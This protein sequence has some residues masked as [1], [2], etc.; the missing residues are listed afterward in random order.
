MKNL[1]SIFIILSII[2]SSLCACSSDV[3]ISGDSS[4]N[5]SGNKFTP[6]GESVASSIFGRS[7]KYDQWTPAEGVTLPIDSSEILDMI[8]IEKVM[9]LLSK[10]GLYSLDIETGESEKII[11]TTD[12]LLASHNKT[13][14]TYGAESGRLCTYSANGELLTEFV[15]SAQTEDLRVDQFFVTDDYYAL[16][17]IDKSE[18]FYVVKYNAYNKETLE[19]SSSFSEKKSTYIP[20]RFYCSYKGNSLLKLEDNGR[21]SAIYAKIAEVDLEKE[22]V[23]D[24]ADVN[25]AGVNSRY[26]ITYNSKTDTALV[27]VAPKDFNNSYPLFI[28]EHS[29]SDPDNIIHQRFHVDFAD[30][31]MPFISVYENIV[32]GIYTAD[33][34]VRYFDYLNPP[35]SI[36][37][38]CANETNYMDI[39]FGFEKETGILVRTVNYG[40]DFTRLDVKLMAGDTDFDLFEPIFLHQHKYYIAG[41]YEDLSK[42]EGLK[43]RLDGDLAAS[44]ISKL[45]DTYVGMP[46]GIV[47]SFTRDSY[48]ED[49]GMNPYSIQMSRLIYLANNVDVTTKMFNDTDGDE[50]YKLLKYLYDNPTGNEKKMPFGNGDDYMILDTGFVVMNPSST[51]K[52]NSVR[53]LEYMFDVLNGNIDG[54][55]PEGRQ[56]INIE[57][58][59][60][61]YAYW[62]IFAWNYVEPIFNATNTI[63]RCDGKNSTIKEIAREAAMEVRMRLE[64]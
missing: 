45:G 38:A 42:Y 33:N 2:M 35:E 55:V 8:Q 49:G 43:K 28:S 18:D 30:G 14:Y 5:N 1:L 57:S 46:T 13:L 20:Q 17:C 53:F 25:I 6:T 16:V 11:D 61:V 62:H 24:L 26:N 36:T 19:L 27:L 51:S 50:L 21:F 37:L 39:I 63:S 3:P 15:I 52:Q 59:E 10:D 7:V 29:L 56:Y 12:V 34:G 48:D 64:E 32:C 31:A 54:V 58:T 44:Y 9:Y 23:L 60:G 41:M 4:G 47:N 40:Q 22:K